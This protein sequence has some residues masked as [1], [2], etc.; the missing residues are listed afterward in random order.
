MWCRSQRGHGTGRGDPLHPVLSFSL[1]RHFR[2]EKGTGPRKLSQRLL[3]LFLGTGDKWSIAVRRLPSNGTNGSNS[4][5]VSKAANSHSFDL[6]FYFPQSTSVFKIKWR[7]HSGNTKA[8]F[9]LPHKHNH[10]DIHTRKMAYL[11]QFSIPALLNPRI[12]K[13]ADDSSAI[14][15]LIC[16]HEVWVKVTFDWSTALCLC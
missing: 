14:L 3:V 5:P 16:S 13:M 6:N 11:T 1:I 15:L 4:L 10:K 9:S 7:L 12:N 2:N 8:W